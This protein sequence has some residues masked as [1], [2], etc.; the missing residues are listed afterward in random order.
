ME[1]TLNGKRDQRFEAPVS[2]TELL[3]RLGL[4]GR[5]VLVELDGTALRPRDFDDRTVD[6]GAVVEII[7][8]AAGG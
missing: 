2:V 3:R 1:I 5:P 7:Q 6:D 8:I 4:G